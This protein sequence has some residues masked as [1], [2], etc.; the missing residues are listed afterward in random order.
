M[1]PGW[2]PDLPAPQSRT[3]R[4]RPPSYSTNHA[5]P[6]PAAAWAF[7]AGGKG[8]TLDTRL[9]LNTGSARAHVGHKTWEQWLG[10]R[11]AQ[12]LRAVSGDLLS[13][14]HKEAQPTLPRAR[15]AN[16]DGVSSRARE[17][18]GRNHCQGSLPLSR[19][20]VA[21][22]LFPLLSP[23]LPLAQGRHR[24]VCGVARLW[25]W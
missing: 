18:V 16:A 19:H 20:Y 1:E 17:M 22:V 25:G 13:L 15:L 6:E 8:R 3:Q 14:L 4:K 21:T 9:H 5:S 24:P 12:L 23:H 7:C 10:F 2:G 11:V